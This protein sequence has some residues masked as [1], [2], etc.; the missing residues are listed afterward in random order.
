MNRLKE[1]MRDD[2][3]KEETQTSNGMDKS[4]I[5]EE[6]KDEAVTSTRK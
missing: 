6:T 2:E 1:E 5:K 3:I 4:E